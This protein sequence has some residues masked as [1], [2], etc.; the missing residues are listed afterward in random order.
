MIASKKNTLRC[1]ICGKF[2]VK[3]EIGK[4]Y[5]E[6]GSYVCTS[7]LEKYEEP[8]FEEIAIKYPHTA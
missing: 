4:Y 8:Y 3:S 7:C 5:A 1:G 2:L 6:D